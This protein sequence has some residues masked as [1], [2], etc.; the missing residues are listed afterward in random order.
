MKKVFYIIVPI[1]ILSLS[2]FLFISNTQKYYTEVNPSKLSQLIEK[3][4]SIIVFFKQDG[5]PHCEQ[6]NPIVND[7][8]KKKKIKV[9]SVTINKYKTS[10][11]I[12]K[13]NISGTPVLSLYKK[14]KEKARLVGGFTKEKFSKFI[15]K[16]NIE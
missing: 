16:N 12:K 4:E 1:L 13:Y 5:C 3:K 8:A 14:G 9:Y 2:T 7:Y 11:V 15:E 6:V 10:Q